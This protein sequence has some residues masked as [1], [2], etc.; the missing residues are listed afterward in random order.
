MNEKQSKWQPVLLLN[1]KRVECECGAL[2]VVV[3]LDY[4]DVPPGAAYKA[5]CQP[6]F[7]RLS[8]EVE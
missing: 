5:W 2:A 8:E 6:C 7:I 3:S 1:E 4:E